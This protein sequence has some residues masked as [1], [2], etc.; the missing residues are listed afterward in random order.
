MTVIIGIAGPSCSGKT[1][2]ARLVAARLDAPLL[3]LDKHWV[4]GCE[5]PVVNGHPSYERPHQYDGKRLMEAADALSPAHAYVVVEGFLLFAY[6]RAVQRCGVR[7]L[8]DAP[9]AVLAERRS[10]RSASGRY[11]GVWD[12]ANADVD[13]GWCAHGKDEWERFGR[14]QDQVPG[15]VVLDGV[16]PPNELAASILKLAIQPP[17]EASLARSMEDCAAGRVADAG[18]VERRIRTR[19]SPS[20]A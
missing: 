3:H 8:I 2:V 7:I 4:D 17:I 19:L 16:R 12:G 20:A 9:H 11:D 10:A 5:K 1:T 6:P 15:I 13:A 18:E 14:Q